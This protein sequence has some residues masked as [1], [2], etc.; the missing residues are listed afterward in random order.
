VTFGE[1]HYG[2]V[3]RIHLKEIIEVSSARALL[4]VQVQEVGGWGDGDPD[5]W[6][7]TEGI[8][9]PSITGTHLRLQDT[10]GLPPSRHTQPRRPPI[11]FDCEPELEEGAAQALVGDE[12]GYGQ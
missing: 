4:M 11:A 9:V 7:S 1:L 5:N 2:E 8:A 3:L 6:C 10:L 12:L